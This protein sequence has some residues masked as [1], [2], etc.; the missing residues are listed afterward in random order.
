MKDSV[1]IICLYWVGKFRGRDFTEEDVIRLRQTVDKHMDRPYKFY[2][3]TNDMDADIPAEK[4]ELDYAWPG[5]WSKMELHRPD[6]PSGRTLY[7]DLDSHVINSLGPMLDYPGNLIMFNTRTTKRKQV[8]G[9]YYFKREGIVWKYQ[10]AV[11]L[12]DPGS[13]SWV[14]NK[15]LEDPDRWMKRFRSEQDLMGEWIPDQPLFPEHWMIKLATFDRHPNKSIDG[16]I[17]ITGQPK[18]VSFREPKYAPWLK[19]LAR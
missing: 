5:W 13:T 11:M 10:A 6:L 16:T 14:Y 9:D 8:M 2:C 19:E 7:L 15:F 1:N 4:I 18:G 17:I 12:F 3:L